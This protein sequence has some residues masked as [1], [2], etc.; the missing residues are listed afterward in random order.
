MF[1][2]FVVFLRKKFFSFFNSLSLTLG[3]FWG[4]D[5]VCRLYFTFLG[6]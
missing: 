6:K 3:N 1:R 4:G 5:N 2:S